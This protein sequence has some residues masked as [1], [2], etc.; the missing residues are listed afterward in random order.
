MYFRYI[1]F[2][3]MTICNQIRVGIK[4]KILSCEKLDNVVLCCVQSGSVCDY[5]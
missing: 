5:K 3:T 4:K 1:D 2:R